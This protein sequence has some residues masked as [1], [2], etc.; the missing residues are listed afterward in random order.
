MSPSPLAKWPNVPACY[1]WLSLD[2]RG[3]WRLQGERVTHQGLIDFLNNN[4]GAEPSGCWFVQN[5][6]QRVY[7]D[8]ACTP[9][10][11]RCEGDAFVSHTGRPAGEV[12]ALYLDGEGRL[13]VDSELGVGLLD[14]RDLAPWLEACRDSDGLTITEAAFVRLLDGEPADI[15]WGHLPLCPLLAVDLEKHFNFVASPRP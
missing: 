2:A 7:V 5:G 12:R 13:L 1:E 14:D 8:L 15:L 3:V 9:W 11:F 10:I 6:P 4:Y